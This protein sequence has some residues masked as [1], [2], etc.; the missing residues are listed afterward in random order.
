MEIVQDYFTIGK[1]IY[2]TSR[3]GKS[4]FAYCISSG[5]I[6]SDFYISS[7]E[8]KEITADST[9]YGS[10]IGIYVES[11][12]LFSEVVYFLG[13]KKKD[14]IVNLIIPLDALLKEGFSLANGRNN[15]YRKCVSVF[16]AER[17]VKKDTIDE[18]YCSPHLVPW[19]LVP[20]EHDVIKYVDKHISKD[21]HILEIGSGLG[22]N[23]LLLQSLGYTNCKGLEYSQNAVSIARC[24]SALST[25][26]AHGDITNACYSSESVDAILD[27]G[28]IH[29]I[30]SELR[31]VAL[32]EVVRILKARGIFISRCFLP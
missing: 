7:D 23:L 17:N 28:C 20:R 9:W 31:R 22:K 1:K 30:P 15:S 25:C 4:F 2:L 5:N 13:A 27:I 19:N 14:C 29:C 21:A 10:D 11:V 26:C 16:E 3:D 12:N 18:L 8:E 6:V 32:S 24:F